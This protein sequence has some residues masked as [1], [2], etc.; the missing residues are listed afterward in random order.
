MRRI[1]PAIP[2]ALP[3]P[4]PAM[5]S[6]EEQRRQ[7][8]LERELQMARDIQQGL[9]LAA[10]PQLRGWEMSAVSS[11]ARD[12]GGD[13]YDFL[14][15][16][17]HSQA[18]MIGDVS[19]KGLAAA[20]RMAVART[21]FR[22]KARL[23]LSPGPTLA[24][25]NREVCTDIPQGM[26]TMLYAVLDTAQGKIQ[27]AN[28]GHTYAVLFNTEAREIEL[29][30]LPLGVDSDSDYEEDGV[31]I[32]EGDSMLL[33]TDGVT[34]AISPDEEEF[35]FERLQLLLQTHSHFK[36]RALMK[37][38][39]RELRSWSQSTEQSDDITIVIL[40][41]RLTSL[42]A[43]L[44]SIVND[45]LGDEKSEPFWL[46]YVIPLLGDRPEDALYDAWSAILPDLTK[47]ARASLG[48]GMARELGQ[49]LRLVAEEYRPL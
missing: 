6:E 10:V 3:V 22:H 40:R 17:D 14:D 46:E 9:L 24:E 47:S 43:E 35:G 31:I 4:A 36:P 11:P 48:R 33:Y 26:I 23:C 27:M 42:G 49:Q 25:V 30:G 5:P 7:A 12:L 28:A 34:E 8:E 20:L 39:L 21:V 15:L 45:V 19:G 16:G 2:D 18:I 13:L 44:R 38:L 37:L 32:P 41:R 29:P 1:E